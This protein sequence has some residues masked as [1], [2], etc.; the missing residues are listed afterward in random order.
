MEVLEFDE[1]QKNIFID[2]NKLFLKW[3]VILE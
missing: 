1:K 2:K 3:I